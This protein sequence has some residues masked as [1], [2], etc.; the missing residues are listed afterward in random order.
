MG[1][2]AEFPLIFRNRAHAPAICGISA[3]VPM[4]EG[5]SRDRQGTRPASEG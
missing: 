2:I 4:D 1:T 3:I 5:R